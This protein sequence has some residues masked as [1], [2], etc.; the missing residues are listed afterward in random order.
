MRNGS[1]EHRPVL[2]VV[3]GVAVSAAL[4]PQELCAGC[5]AVL[6]AD[7]EWCLECG[8]ARTAIGQPPDWRIGAGVVLLVVV[9]AVAALVV[10][11]P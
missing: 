3:R 11:L 9:L 6:A 7:Q 10:A 5:G 8:A 4:S 1:R 2:L